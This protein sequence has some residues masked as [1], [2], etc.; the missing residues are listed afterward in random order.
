MT[1]P[2]T[3]NKT[4]PQL[5]TQR[6]QS[7]ARIDLG[8]NTAAISGEMN[9]YFGLLIGGNTWNGD[10][11][12]IGSVNIISG[13]LNQVSVGSLNIEDQYVVTNSLISGSPILDGGLLVNRGTS[14]DANVKWNETS[15]SWEVGT[16]SQ[17]Y[18]EITFNGMGVGKGAGT[19]DAQLELGVGRTGSGNAYLDLHA[20]SGAD[21]SARV[22]R[23]GGTNGNLDIVN[24]GTGYVSLVDGYGKYLVVGNGVGINT[25]TPNTDLTVVGKV[26]ILDTTQ[27][28]DDG[29]IQVQNSTAGIANAGV[30]T[31]NHY[32][33][34]QF[35]QWEDYGIRFGSRIVTN[36]GKGGINITTGSDSISTIISAG[37]MR[38]G[39]GL[40]PNIAPSH[41]LQVDGNASIGDVVTIANTSYGTSSAV[42]GNSQFVSGGALYFKG[43]NG[44]ITLLAPA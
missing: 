37:R 9:S 40:V 36:G 1:L 34:S 41:V 43:S 17:V 7:Q 21:F 15:D 22:I 8:V 27:T 13:S 19:D 11:T 20:V 12:I 5:V 3:V 24:T 28:D 25:T 2:I 38:I 10:Q 26:H 6:G 4:F 35:M 16:E 30:N 29:M 14:T 23:N 44:T 33:T 18:T 32:G 39:N 31:K 42:P